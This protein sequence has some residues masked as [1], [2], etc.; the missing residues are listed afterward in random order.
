MKY[1]SNFASDASP[2]GG[3]IATTARRAHIDES[4]NN[5]IPRMLRLQRVA[6]PPLAVDITKLG[7]SSPRLRERSAQTATQLL[8]ERVQ[9]HPSSTARSASHPGPGALS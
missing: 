3:V 8:I 1:L 5:V 2:C 9:Y 7:S 6:T 4:D